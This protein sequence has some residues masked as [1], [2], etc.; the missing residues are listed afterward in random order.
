MT[1]Q[2]TVKIVKKETPVYLKKIPET[3]A[4]SSE[5]GEEGLF[6]EPVADFFHR[7]DLNGDF[8][9]ERSLSFFFPLA[10]VATQNAT[11]D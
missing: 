1:G 8:D 5:G 9:R 3:L 7:N 10:L 11:L 6:G 4:S 2:L